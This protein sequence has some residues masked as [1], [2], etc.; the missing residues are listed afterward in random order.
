MLFNVSIP[1]VSFQVEI[2][3]DPTINER[4]PF[5][6][7]FDGDE[8]NSYLDRET[9]MQAAHEIARTIAA[10]H[11]VKVTRTTKRKA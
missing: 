10:S 7:Y 4:Y 9:A 11:A 6:L 3:R 1:A 5:V 8:Y 2:V